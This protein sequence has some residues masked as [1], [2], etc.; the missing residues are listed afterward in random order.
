MKKSIFA[1]LF[2]SLSA[3]I[4]AMPNKVVFQ[5]LSEKYPDAAETKVMDCMTCHT[6]DKWQRNEYGLD[7]E[8]YLRTLAINTGET[9]DPSQYTKD[10]IMKGMKAIE[11]SDSDNDGFSNL[12]ELANGTFPGDAADF[13]VRPKL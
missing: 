9:Q 12:E 4:M 5:A 13:P 3:P 1:F 2:L 11:L 6:I 8:N 7:L 10:F